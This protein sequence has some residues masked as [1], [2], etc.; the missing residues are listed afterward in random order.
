MYVINVSFCDTDFFCLWST[1]FSFNHHWNV[2]KSTCF[3]M[4]KKE[5]LSLGRRH[6]LN[7][8]LIYKMS[9]TQISHVI[10][11]TFSILQHR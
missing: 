5:N 11:R 6:M 4:R 9:D 10:K 7:V 1:V 2:L 8:D 3:D